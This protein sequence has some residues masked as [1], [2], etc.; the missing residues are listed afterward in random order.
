[1]FYLLYIL[2]VVEDNLLLIK[3]DLLF[4]PFLTVADGYADLHRFDPGPLLTVIPYR[5]ITLLIED[6]VL[7]K[8]G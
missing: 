6:I 2:P 5:N 1:M 3:K 4:P 7:K 8:V